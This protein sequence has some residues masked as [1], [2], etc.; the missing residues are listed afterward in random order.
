MYDESKNIFDGEKIDIKSLFSCYESKQK[1][2][3]TNK[4]KTFPDINIQNISQKMKRK[5][6]KYEYGY[7]IMEL[8]NF[9]I[10]RDN[11]S[12]SMLII[13]NSID[14]LLEEKLGNNLNK[15]IIE[16]ISKFY[17]EFIIKEIVIKEIPSIKDAKIIYI[18]QYLLYSFCKVYEEK[19]K[20]EL[21]LKTEEVKKKKLNFKNIIE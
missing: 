21:D 17:E 6:L 1:P 2:R 9:D 11:I 5:D 16:I 15:E 20:E 18:F 14:K 3:I 12:E 8:Y 13:I 4:W 7:R 10:F 19:Y